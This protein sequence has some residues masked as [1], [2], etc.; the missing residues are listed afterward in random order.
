MHVATFLRASEAETAGLRAL[1]CRAQTA[2]DIAQVS[3]PM[4]ETSRDL[5]DRVA[6]F[7]R[8]QRQDDLLETA[9]EGVDDVAGEALGADL[10][11][12]DL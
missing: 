12:H 6:Q 10:P 1:Y 7:A 8:G 2:G 11:A 4:D 9:P 3:A 5:G